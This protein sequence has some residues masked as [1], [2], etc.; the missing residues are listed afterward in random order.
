[1]FIKTLLISLLFLGI[2]S[3]EIVVKV[4]IDLNELTL[5]IG[6]AKLKKK[7]ISIASIENL[8]KVSLFYIHSQ[9]TFLSSKALQNSISR[10][11]GVAQDFTIMK[12]EMIKSEIPLKEKT[13]EFMR[14][15]NI[16]HIDQAS[17]QKLSVKIILESE[18]DIHI[19]LG[20]LDLQSVFILGMDAENRS[21]VSLGSD[22]FELPA[23][24]K[25]QFESLKNL[26][27]PFMNE[28]GKLIQSDAFIFTSKHTG[29]A[30]VK[31]EPSL[32]QSFRIKLYPDLT[33]MLFNKNPSFK[34]NYDSNVEGLFTFVVI[35][36][37]PVMSDFK[38]SNLHKLNEF[39]VSKTGLNKLVGM[40]NPIIKR[41]ETFTMSSEEMIN[42]M[43]EVQQNKKQD[44]HSKS[45]DPLFDFSVLMTSFVNSVDFQVNTDVN[46]RNVYFTWDQQD[47]DFSLTL[48]TLDT[49]MNKVEKVF[50]F[51]KSTWRKIKLAFV[52]PGRVGTKVEQLELKPSIRLNTDLF[53]ESDYC[54]TFNQ[55][56]HVIENE[57]IVSGLIHTR[58]HGLIDKL[59][60]EKTHLMHWEMVTEILADGETLQ[61]VFYNK[62]RGAIVQLEDDK[63]VMNYADSLNYKSNGLT[64]PIK[65]GLENKPLHDNIKSGDIGIIRTTVFDDLYLDMVPK[66]LIEN[67]RFEL[68]VIYAGEKVTS[69]DFMR[70]FVQNPRL[71]HLNI[72]SS[73]RNCLKRFSKVKPI[74]LSSERVEL[75][76]F[77]TSK[78]VEVMIGF[79]KATFLYKNKELEIDLTFEQ[80]EKNK[81]IS[82]YSKRNSCRYLQTLPLQKTLDN[83]SYPSFLV[84]VGKAEVNLNN[85]QISSRTNE[86]FL[87]LNLKDLKTDQLSEYQLAGLTVDVDKKTCSIPSQ[88][89]LRFELSQTAFT[90][91]DSTSQ[92]SFSSPI[93]MIGNLLGFK[94]Y[95]FR[96]QIQKSLQCVQKTKEINP[97][98]RTCVSFSGQ[99]VDLSKI[100][101][102]DFFGPKI[103]SLNQPRIIFSQKANKLIL[104]YAMQENNCQIS[105]DKTGLTIDGPNAFKFNAPLSKVK[106][107]SVNPLKRY[108]TVNFH[109]FINQ[110]EKI[111]AKAVFDVQHGI[112]ENSFLPDLLNLAFTL[113]INGDRNYLETFLLILI[114]SGSR[115]EADCF[116]DS[117]GELSIVVYETHYFASDLIVNNLLQREP[118]STNKSKVIQK[119]LMKTETLKELIAKKQ[120]DKLQLQTKTQKIIMVDENA[121][122]SPTENSLCS[123]KECYEVALFKMNEPLT[124]FMISKHAIIDELVESQNTLNIKKEISGQTRM[125]GCTVFEFKPENVLLI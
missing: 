37:E 50:R 125:E 14:T 49:N 74:I 85:L 99:I 34:I 109:L 35:S 72:D 121:G 54:E 76:I 52:L 117:K 61:V 12:S 27:I 91:F 122:Q 77:P 101:E 6:E 119:N 25:E 55:L 62:K 1:M 9:D 114:R 111:E 40:A 33:I 87:L 53:N 2:F 11:F 16:N 17:L 29:I 66:K 26:Q 75:V 113:P 67:Q 106:L 73:G 4:V 57:L 20:E 64:I 63:I 58:D 19:F 70:L 93:V 43:E 108:F 46:N 24:V 28:V 104:D 100:I 112:S 31:I 18:T 69:L 10:I 22:T 84:Y 105:L 88:S 103:N 102:N 3:E 60:D 107:H 48:K 95:Q 44:K 118:T 80:S 65:T 92:R 96:D 90:L 21:Y 59:I 8:Q 89:L 47:N 110:I 71:Y 30:I 36:Q 41:K 79:S 94:L 120:A 116:E 83:P 82:T 38:C 32:I 81:L 97:A 123:E 56:S 23:K 5:S 15:I 42:M 45:A 51:T 7:R 68:S 124:Y 39:T 78:V 13:A 86:D 115:F 98:A